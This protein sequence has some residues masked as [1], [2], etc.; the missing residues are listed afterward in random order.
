LANPTHE[1]PLCAGNLA[2][3]S[4]K[5]RNRIFASTFIQKLP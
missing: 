2:Y 3:V 5:Q 1:A 4:V